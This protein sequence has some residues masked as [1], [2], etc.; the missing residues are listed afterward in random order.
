MVESESNSMNEL[1]PDVVVGDKR[2]H[3]IA[4]PDAVGDKVIAREYNDLMWYWAT[5]DSMSDQCPDRVTGDQ[6]DSRTN[7]VLMR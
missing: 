7:N 2:Q 4:C 6:T 1:R 3:E 5:S